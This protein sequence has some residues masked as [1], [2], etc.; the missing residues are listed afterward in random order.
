MPPT[1]ALVASRPFSDVRQPALNLTYVV[2]SLSFVLICGTFLACWSIARRRRRRRPIYDISPYY[3][4]DVDSLNTPVLPPNEVKKPV[5]VVSALVTQSTI[6]ASSPLRLKII[7]NLG[8]PSAPRRSIGLLYHGFQR[9]QPASTIGMIASSS[10]ASSN[11]D[12]SHRRATTPL[13]SALRQLRAT[14]ILN[15]QPVASSATEYAEPH[16]HL[17]NPTDSATNK[18]EPEAD[19]VNVRQILRSTDDARCKSETPVIPFI[20]LSLPSN[21]YLAE[22]APQPRSLDE[23]LLSPE[24]TFRSTGPLARAAADTHDI[25]DATR[26]ALASRLRERRKCHIPLPPPNVFVTPNIVRWPR[27]F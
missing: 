20:I 11:S 8:Y 10:V 12:D 13:L 21:E 19:T 2:L 14:R 9:S 15:Q 6:V 27:W 24:G 3:F 1:Q 7:P 17:S 22:E 5:P 23:D 18:D 16:W 26:L 25:S 4:T